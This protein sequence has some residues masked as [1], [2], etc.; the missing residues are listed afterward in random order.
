[1]KLNNEKELVQI[2]KLN[3]ENDSVNLNNL[4]G[5]KELTRTMNSIKL[6]ESYMKTKLYKWNESFISKNLLYKNDSPNIRIQ[7]VRKDSL[8]KRTQGV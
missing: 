2:I 8:I 6:Y 4:F 5:L 3:M 7:C 1:M